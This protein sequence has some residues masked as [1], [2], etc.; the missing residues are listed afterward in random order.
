MDPSIVRDEKNVSGH[1]DEMKN[2]P[3]KNAK[4]NGRLKKRFRIIALAVYFSVFLPAYAKRHY[5][6]RLKLLMQDYPHEV[7][8]YYKNKSEVASSKY[9]IDEA[10]LWNFFDDKLNILDAI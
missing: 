2:K 7:E 10:K 4:S 8:K 9:K 3:K 1:V 6:N 5:Q